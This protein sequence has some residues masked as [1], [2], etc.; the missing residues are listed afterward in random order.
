[1]PIPE[2]MVVVGGMVVVDGIMVVEVIVDVDGIVVIVD[3]LLPEV[4]V[5]GDVILVP[6]VLVAACAA[7]ANDTMRSAVS[8]ILRFICCSPCV[9]IFPDDIP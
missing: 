9:C 2:F 5:V 8:A 7:A 3:I 4:M 6:G 1:M